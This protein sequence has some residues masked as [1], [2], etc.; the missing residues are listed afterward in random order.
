[1][2]LQLL[3]LQFLTTYC[4]YLW[5][6]FK[7]MVLNSIVSSSTLNDV[8]L[9]WCFLNCESTA[10]CSGYSCSTAAPPP[11]PWSY[12]DKRT[13]PYTWVTDLSSVFI[14]DSSEDPSKIR[15]S[16]GFHVEDYKLNKMDW[17]KGFRTICQNTENFTT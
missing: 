12:L 4:S 3:P 2:P 15:D 13:A 14:S 6:S 8:G 17:S 10:V 11:G 1:M 7:D 16:R 5:L 9:T